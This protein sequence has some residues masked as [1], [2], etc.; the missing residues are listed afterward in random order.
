MRVWVDGFQTWQRDN[1]PFEIRRCRKIIQRL[2]SDKKKLQCFDPLT[3]ATRCL[4]DILVRKAEALSRMS[5]LQK[6]INSKPTKR[7]GPARHINHWLAL[8]AYE[9]GN[10]AQSDASRNKFRESFRVGGRMSKIVRVENRKLKESI[11]STE[12]HLKYK[13]RPDILKPG[14]RPPPLPSLRVNQD[15]T[16]RWFSDFM[17]KLKIHISFELGEEIYEVPS[18]VRHQLIAEAIFDLINLQDGILKPIATSGYGPLEKAH[19]GHIK[20]AFLKTTKLAD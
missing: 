5:T 14:P 1:A 11:D 18:D 13:K 17:K 6:F 8:H 9:L 12:G 4:D 16:G 19:L 7:R 15:N 3:M 2:D 20:P 10:T